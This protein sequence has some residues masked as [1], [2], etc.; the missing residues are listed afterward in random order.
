MNSEK[1]KNHQAKITAGQPA[2][3]SITNHKAA[4]KEVEKKVSKQERLQT[5]EGWKRAQSKR[6]KEGSQQ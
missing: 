4:K 1:E 3:K 2:A 5:A 6:N